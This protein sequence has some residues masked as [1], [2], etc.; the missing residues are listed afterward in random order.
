[1]TVRSREFAKQVLQ[2]EFCNLRVIP[3]LDPG[4]HLLRKRK[5]DCRI[6]SGNDDGKRRMA[7]ATFAWS[8]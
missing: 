2:R 7:V 5:M 1:M 4:I 6:K 3:G 8:K